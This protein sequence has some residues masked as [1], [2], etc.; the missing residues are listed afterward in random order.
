MKKKREPKAI[1]LHVSAPFITGNLFVGIFNGCHDG[2]REA[3]AKC[4][5]IIISF[6]FPRLF[7]SRV[8]LLSKRPDRLNGKGIGGAF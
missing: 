4:C 8:V 5:V 7:E 2:Q 6:L 1:R 3:V